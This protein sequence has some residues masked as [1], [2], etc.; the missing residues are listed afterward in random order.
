MSHDKEN[1]FLCV[2]LPKKKVLI[3]I[4]GDSTYIL[5][6]LGLVGFYRVI[7]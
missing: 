1:F 7:L 5:L 4:I 3:F 2:L 6:I